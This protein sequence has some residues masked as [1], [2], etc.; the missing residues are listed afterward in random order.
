MLDILLLL[1]PYLPLAQLDEVL[2]LCIEK[3]L[4]EHT[5][6]GVQKLGYRVIGR[7]VETRV[8]IA[9][10]NAEIVE[11]ILKEIGK[12]SSVASGSV[13]VKFNLTFHHSY[14]LIILDR[15]A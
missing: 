8:K 14:K 3:K 9:G 5:E 15:N 2:R 1:I 6:G 4:T 7:T 10:E 11:N 13:K 12:G